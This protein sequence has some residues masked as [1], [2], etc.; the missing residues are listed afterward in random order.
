MTLE[1]PKEAPL[2]EIDVHYNTIINVTLTDGQ[3]HDVSY[4]L[5]KY[6]EFVLS[7]L[8]KMSG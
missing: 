6:S 8:S 5:K 2:L 1:S 3:G 4:S 7:L